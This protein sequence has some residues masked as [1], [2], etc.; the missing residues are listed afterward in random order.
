MKSSPRL[1][2]FA[3]ILGLTVFVGACGSQW[4]AAGARKDSPS[5]RMLDAQI[6]YD[7]SDFERSAQELEKVLAAD[8][9]NAEARV[10]LAFAYNAKAGLGLLD[11]AGKVVAARVAVGPDSNQASTYTGAFG[12]T[13]AEREALGIQLVAKS[14]DRPAG[15]TRLDFS[16]LTLAEIRAAS[17]KLSALHASFKSACRFLP[18]LVVEQALRATQGPGFDPERVLELETAC[19]GGAPQ[20]QLIQ[21]KALL[22]LS[23]SSLAQ[24]V[25]LYQLA[26][27][28]GREGRI[29]LA[30]DGSALQ[31][32]LEQLRSEVERFNAREGSYAA[33]NGKMGE[34]NQAFSS[35]SSLGRELSGEVF[36]GMAAHI[37]LVEMLISGNKSLP[38]QVRGKLEQALVKLGEG[39][40]AAGA[41][42]SPDSAIARDPLFALGTRTTRQQGASSEDKMGSL[43]RK[44]ANAIDSAF[45]K[46]M[47]SIAADTKLSVEEKAAWTGELNARY[48]ESCQRIGELRSVLGRPAL[49]MPA[50][51]D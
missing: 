4:S 42:L 50:R 5:A 43:A 25:I 1:S 51:C 21:T 34:L 19:R 13:K 33:L 31:N 27:D 10:R 30:E 14:K 49:E 7:A 38:K 40:A 37:N 16:Q 41:Y 17:P 36:S 3:S 28:D 18:K 15:G 44:A 32:K 2:Q 9:E 8:P 29:A 47:R 35:V 48:Q 11:F 23:I 20:G 24:A 39:R 45:A 46:Q 12:L 6:A 26:E 22:A